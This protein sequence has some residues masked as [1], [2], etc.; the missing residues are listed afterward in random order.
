MST[1]F[2]REEKAEALFDKISNDPRAC[3]RLMN[4]FYEGIA[5]DEDSSVEEERVL[6]DKKVFTDALF[7]AYKNK[8]LSAFLMAVCGN[9]MFDLLRNAFLIPLRFNDKG[10]ENP[11]LLSDVNGNI[12]EKMHI[13]EMKKHMFKKIQKENIYLAYGFLEQHSFQEDMSIQTIENE[14]HLGIL[15]IQDMPK[16]VHEK[17]SDAQIYSVIWDYM[18]K[19]EDL[20][21]NAFFYC[22][23][24]NGKY[25]LGVFLPLT[26][27]EHNLEKNIE[28]AQ[29]VLLECIQ[30]LTTI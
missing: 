27:F 24:L 13:P 30:K 2:P 11:V 20:L 23:D 3:K 5:C 18:M 12:N 16:M 7:M 14:S 21:Y 10:K 19:L 1:I 15:L 9:S 4:A 17:L 6:P 22:G 28:V 25:R 29:G 8:D 26:H